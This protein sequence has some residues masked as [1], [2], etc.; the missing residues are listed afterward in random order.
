MHGRKPKGTGLAGLVAAQ[1]RLEAVGGPLTQEG[2]A[3]LAA[4]RLVA[5]LSSCLTCL[6][7]RCL[8]HQS[9]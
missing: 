1:R 6:K 2:R 4:L 3:V 8:V 9:S 5:G 7:G